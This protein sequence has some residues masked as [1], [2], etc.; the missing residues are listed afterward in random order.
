[1]RYPRTFESTYSYIRH[2]QLSVP[3]NPTVV[4]KC[5]DVK[6][7]LNATPSTLVNSSSTNNTPTRE[8]TAHVNRQTHAS[9]RFSLMDF[10]NPASPAW[11]ALPHLMLW[12]FCLFLRH[13]HFVYLCSR[14]NTE[15][16]RYRTGAPST[17]LW[18]PLLGES[19]W[20]WMSSNVLLSNTTLDPNVT[21]VFERAPGLRQPP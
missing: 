12:F 6:T 15:H 16:T 8:S 9:L 20:S 11:S 4:A 19:S 10:S 7:T 17:I 5:S 1:V 13:C 2:R 14:T 21:K 18:I 3:T